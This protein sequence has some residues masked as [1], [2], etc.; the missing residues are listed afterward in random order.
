MS[1]EKRKLETA[2][3]VVDNK[4][5]K[6]EGT[7]ISKLVDSGEKAKI[8]NEFNKH[9]EKYSNDGDA[10]TIYI[11]WMIDNPDKYEKKEIDT[12]FGK[13]L[14]KIYHIE[15]W[16]LYLKYVQMNN[17]ITPDEAE[18]SR[19]IVLKA[20]KFAT[21]TVG[22][23]Y[24]EGDK[25]WT[26]YLKYLSEWK[27]SNP[28]EVETR[29]SLI[30]K[31]LRTMISFPSKKLSDHWK[32][33]TQFESSIDIVKS[34]K[35]IS[36]A[37]GEIVKVRKLNSE[38]EKIIGGIAKM[39]DRNYSVRQF[40]RWKRWIE[41]EKKNP[42]ELS[43]DEMIKRVEFV[44]NQSIQYGR[45]MPQIWINYGN[46]LME[47]GKK[48]KCI[49]ILKEGLKANPIS[50][51][52]I[53]GLS[54]I[55]ELEGEGK[56][57]DMKILWIELI[58]NIVNDESF[59]KSKVKRV[60]SFCYCEL[61]RT[62]NRVSGLKEVRPIFKRARQYKEI[63]WN[64]YY[65]YSMIEYN[66]GESKIASRSF[67]LGMQ[68]FKDE[69]LFVIKYLEFLLCIKD[70]VTFKNVIEKSIDNFQDK[71]DLES[72]KKVM[73]KYYDVETQFGDIKLINRLCERYDNI[74]GEMK[75][76]DLIV[77]EMEGFTPNLNIIKE[78]D[79]YKGRIKGKNGKEKEEGIGREGNEEFVEEGEDEDEEEYTPDANIS[80]PGKVA[81]AETSVT[82]ETN[83]KSES[84]SGTLEGIMMAL[85]SEE[86]QG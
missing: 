53:N 35:I 82:G 74:F 48:N 7:E 86:K 27:A 79:E 31:A 19:S 75:H 17:P 41:W 15:L 25:I 84:E 57:E 21:D 49:E 54:K 59:D 44:Y 68:T 18:K 62:M 34:R 4:K 67:S 3:D 37:S 20:F 66:N 24:F 10:W 1:G 51:I 52:L 36:D 65:E 70:M 45:F 14:T 50:F 12:A 28:N 77:N 8:D 9:F 81:V 38:L 69:V 78:L 72:L 22:I 11:K 46:Y 83:M 5:A 43:N 47:S 64:V 58:D 2:V 42:L 13:V 32:A 23:D 55:Y 40:R 76:L 61:M 30:R 63:E 16:R 39:K 26:D 60:I 6:V 33:F 85:Q 29:E 73:N 71:G 80:S 56:V